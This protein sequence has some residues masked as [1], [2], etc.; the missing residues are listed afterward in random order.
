MFG[1]GKKRKKYLSEFSEILSDTGNV[2]LSQVKDFVDKYENWI[3]SESLKRDLE[4]HVGVWNVCEKS[5]ERI[6]LAHQLKDYEGAKIVPNYFLLAA[7]KFLKINEKTAADND[8]PAPKSYL[9]AVLGLPVDVTNPEVTYQ[10]VL[11]DLAKD[12]P[13]ITVNE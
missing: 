7:F 6:Y 13:T 9:P 8:F 2:P 11:K 1:F 10:E 3:I 4:P 5:M 12:D